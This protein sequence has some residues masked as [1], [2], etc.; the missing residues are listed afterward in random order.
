MKHFYLTKKINNI[1]STILILLGLKEE[2][3]GLTTTTTSSSVIHFDTRNRFGLYS[4]K[5]ALVFLLFA[6]MGAKAQIGV[7][8]TGNTNTTPNLAASYTTLA[9]ALSALNATTAMTGPVTLTLTADTSET[10]PATGLVI[11]SAS[12]NAVLSATNT[13]TIV[14]AGGTVTLNA[15]VGTLSPT[16]TNTEGILKLAGADWITIDGL[17]LTDGNTTTPGTMEVGIGMYKL[18][19][20]DGCN[21]NTIQ[22]CTINM[23]RINN[24]TGTNPIVEGAV[25]IGMYNSTLTAATTVLTVTAASGSNSNNK[26]YSNTINGGNYGMALIGFAAATPF[27][28]ADQGNDI[29]GTSAGTGNQILNFGGGATTNPSAG[30][31][32]LAQYGIS[33]RYNT[34]NNNNGSGVNH[35]ITLRGIY[36]NTATSA[37]ATISNNTVVLKSGAT[38]SEC[39]AIQNA[40]GSTAAS[41]TITISNNN[42]S[43]ANSTSTTGVWSG[44]INSGTA[45]TVNIDGNTMTGFNLA[46]TGTCVMIGT[47]SPTTATASNNSITSITRSGAFGNWRIIITTSPTNFTANGNTIDGLSWTAAAST[48]SIDGIYSNSSAVNVTANNNIIRN[49]STPSTGTIT[50]IKEFGL[51]G[52]KT[53]QNNQIYNFFTTSGGAGGANF[54]GIDEST[55]S[56]NVYS[57]NRIYSF[58]STGSTGGTSGNIVGITFSGGT[59]N[60]VFGNKI[61]DLSS[62]S[63]NPSIEGIKVTGT[64]FAGGLTNN[65]YNNIIGDLKAPAASS[66]DPIRGI[67]ITSITPLSTQNV[68]G[69]TVYLNAASS[70]ANFGSSGLYHTYSAT[71]TTSA[72]DMRNNII[73]NASSSAGT[74]FAVAF[75]RSAATDLA[76]YATTSNNNMFFGTSGLFTDGTNRDTSLSAFQT[77]VST[78]ETASKTQNPSFASTTGADATFL[79]FVA[80]AV[81]LAGSNGQVIAGYTTDFDGDTRDASTPDIG[82]DEWVNGVI[83]LPTITSFSPLVLCTEGGQTVTLTGTGFGTATAV[84]FNGA[85][86]QDSLSG[87]ITAATATSLTV[88]TPVG[89]VDGSITVLNPAGQVTS[90]A[91]Y[92]AASAPTVG[93]SPAATICSG[94]STTLTGTGGAT[95][96]WTPSLGLNGTTTASVIASPT[97]TTTYTVRGFNEFGCNATATVAV[98]V[99]LA[100]PAITATASNT[101]PCIG[102]AVNLTS[103]SGNIPTSSIETFDSVESITANGWTFLNAGFGSAWA[104]TT[105]AARV[106][107]TPGALQYSYNSANAA[108]AWVFSPPRSLTAGITYTI[109][110]WYN[111]GGFAENLKLT[112]GTLNSVASQTTTL[113]TQSGVTNSVFAQATATFTPTTT[114]TYYF[115]LHCFSEADQ[116]FISVDDFTIISPIPATYAWTSSPSGYTSSAQNPTGVTPTVAT[117]Y[118]VE[119]TANGCSKTSS[120]TVTPNAL[121][122]VT[123]NSETVCLGQNATITATPGEAGTYSYAWTVPSG[124]TNPGNEAS[125]SAGTAGNYSVII[126]NTATTCASASASGTITVNQPVVITSQPANSVVLENTQASFSVTATGAGLTY[127][128]YEND[129]G[130]LAVIEGATSATYTINSAA[131]SLNGRLYLCIVTGT[132]STETSSS[133]TL[134]VSDVSIAAQP[135]PQTICSNSSATFSVTAE[136]NVTS[137]QWQVRTSLFSSWTDVLGAN[138]SSITVSGLTATNNSGNNYRCV[139]NAGAVTS[140]Q[141]KLTVYDA[142]AFTTQPASAAVCSGVN[143][144]FNAFA[145]GSGLSYQW[146]MNNG[147][148]WADISGATTASYTVT[149]PTGSMNG[150][151]YRLVASGTAPCTPLVSDAVTLTVTDVSVATSSASICIGGATTLNATFVGAPDYTTATWTSTTGSGAETAVSGASVS[152]TPTAAGSYTYTFASNGTCPFTKTVAVTVN[153]LPIISSVTATPATVCSDANISLAAASV[154]V[155]SGNVLVGT[156][157]TSNTGA[158]YPSPFGN[159]YYGAKQQFLVT[160]SELSALGLA[161]GN[162]TSIAFDVVTPATTPLVNYTIAAKATSNSALTTTFESGLSTLFTAASYVPSASA[163]YN[164]NTITFTTPFNWNGTSNIVFEICFNNSGYTTNAVS[165]ASAAPANS[166][167]FTA[168]DNG[169]VC[170]TSTGTLASVRSNMRFA[171]TLNTNLASTYNWSWNTTPAVATALGTTT[172]TNTSGASVSQTFT[173]TATNAS[174]CTSSLTSTPITVN[175]TI[176]APTATN[177]AQCGTVTPTCSVTGT[178]RVGATFKWYLVATN[179]TALAGQTASTLTSYPTAADT[180]FYVS[181]VSADGLCESPRVAVS[182]TV[183]T[184]FEFTLS[185]ATATNCSGVNSLTPVTIATNDGYTSY[186]W[187]NDATVS[188]NETTGWSF[189]PSTSTT[190]TVTASGGLC[191][192]TANVVVTTTAL[193]VLTATAVP[194]AVCVGAS[195]AI[196]VLTPVIGAGTGAFGTGALTSTGTGAS[197]FPGAW[198]GAKSQYIIKASELTAQGFVA[199]NLTSL[200]FEPTTSGQTYQGFTVNLSSTTDAETTTTFLPVGTQVFSGTGTDGGYTPTANAVNNLAFGT[201]LGSASSFSWNGT[202]NVVVTFSWSL[203]PAAGTSSGSTVKYYAPGFTCGVYKQSDNLAPVDMLA[204]ATG[205]TTTSRPFMTLG[206]QKTIQGVGTLAYTW[207]D[208]SA[209]TGNVLT[210][211]PAA[212][213]V[214]TVSG[215]NATT[216]CTGTS[217]ATVTVFSPPTAPS[218][219]NAN[220]CGTAVPSIAVADTNG[221]T[222]PVF[223]WYAD[224][225]TTTAL[226]TSTSTTYTTSV[227][228]T[229]TFY[230]SVVSPGGCESTRTAVTTTVIAPA[231]LTVSPAVT[232]CTGD[233]TTLTA[234]GAVSYTWTPALGLNGTTGASVSAS[235]S[236]NTTYSVT[237]VDENGCT[238]AAATVAVTVALYPSAVTITQG[239]ASVCADSV[240]SLTATG[241]TIG[242]TGSGKIGS[243]TATNTASTPFKGYF[244]GSKTQQLYTAAELTA[245]GLVSG[246][247]ISSIG[248]VVLSGTPNLLNGFTVN[249]GLVTAATLGTAFIAGANTNVFSNATYTPS[250]G[251]GNIDYALSTPLTWNGISNLLVETCF[252]NNNGGGSF[253][254]DMSVESTTVA[255]GLNLYKAQDNTVDVCTNLAAPTASTNRPNLRISYNAPPTIISWTPTTDLYSNAGATTA[256]SGENA[257]VVYTKPT[258][259]ITYTATASNGACS[260]SNT[261]TVTPLA[262]PNFTLTSNVTICKGQSTTLEALGSGYTYVWT[263]AL[264]LNGTTSAS[265]SA[266]PT[267][268]TTYS[269]EATDSVTGCKATQQVVVTVS[270]PGAINPIGTTTS[271]IAVPGGTATFTVATASGAT[272]TYQWQ[273]NSGS[274]FV[275]VVND[276]TY[277]GAD[278]ASLSISDIQESFDTY[279]YQCLVTGASPCAT[280]TPIVAT[281][282]VSTTGIAQQPASVTLCETNTTT[283]FTV[284]TSGDEPYGIQWQMSTDNGATYND[285]AAGLD[286]TGLTFSGV[287]T[288]TL[289]VSGVSLAN[290]GVKFICV[291]NFFLPSDAATLTVK[292]AV[293]VT[294]QPTNQTVCASGGTA[295]FTTAATGD[296]L[297]YQWEVSTN[298]TTWANY[299]GTGATTA[300]I[301]IVNPAT[302]ADGTQYRVIVSGN[303][304]CTSVTSAAASLLINNPTIT[305]APTAATVLQGN[306]ATFTVTASAATSYQ[307]Q[308]SATLNGTY[309]NVVDAAPAGATYQGADSASLLVLTSSSSASGAG[310]FYRCVV[311]NN[312]CSITSTGVLL[313]VAAYCTPAPS[314]VDGIGITNVTMGDINNTTVAETGNYG[315]YTAYSTTAAQLATVNFA[316]TY[317]TGFNYG[318]KIWIDF[319]DN[320]LFTDAGEQVY[321][322]LSTATNPTTLSGSFVIPLTAAVGSHRMRIGA[323]DTDT[324][325]DPCYTGTFATFEDYTITVTPA[326]TCSGTPLAGTAAAVNG[327]ICTGN[328]TTVNLTGQTTGVTNIVL[329]WYSSTDGTTFT[330]IS[331]ATTATL[332]TGALTANT[333]YYCAVTCSN[334]SETVN[335]NTVIITVQDPQITA[336]TPAGRCG[337]G[338]VSLGATAN[339]GSS[340]NW[341]A[342][343]NGGS[344]IG[345]GTTLTTPSIAATTTYYA[346]AYTGAGIFNGARTAPQVAS[347]STAFGYGLVFDATTAFT[348]NSVDLFNGSTSSGTFVIQL[349]NSAGTVLQTSGTFTAPAGTGSVATNPAYT[350]NLGWNIPVGTGYRLLVTTSSVTLVRESAVGGFPYALGSVGSIT[351]GYISGASTT[352][353]YLYNWKV[354]A[355]CVSTRTAVTATV[356]PQPTAS[357]SYATPLC[358]TATVVPF[359][360][361]GTNAY[362]GGTY[363]STAGLTIDAVTG[364]I[365]VATST[366][367]TYTVT[368]A[369]PD[370]GFCSGLSA[371]TSVTINQALTSDFAYDVATYCTNQG[372]ATPTMTGAAGTFTASPA[373]LSINA[374]TGAITLAS[375]AAGTYTVTNTVVVAGCAN[376]V[377]TASVTVNSAVVITTQ[378]SS[379]SQLPGDNSSFSVAATGTGLAYQWQVNDGTGYVD[380]SGATTNS[381][382]LTAVT[383]EMNGYL[384]QV[385]VSGAAACNSVTSSAALLTVSTAAIAT[386]PANFTACNEGANTAT[387]AVT[388]TGTVTSYQWQLSTNGTTWSDITNGGIY[389][390]ADTATLSLSGLT[391]ANDTNQFRCVLNGVVNSNA[392]TLTIKTAVAITTQPSNTAGCSAGSASF[393]VAASGSD[394]S[395]QWQ[396]STNGTSWTDV[397]GATS[398]TL[399]L[400]ALTA[401]M[402]GYQYQAIVSGAS[403]CSPVTS[404]AAT[405]TVNTAV[406]VSVQP[407]STTACNAANATFS[408]TATGTAPTYQ[409]QMSTNGTSWSDVSGETTASLTVTSVTVAMSGYSYRAVVSGAAP[410]GSVNSS[411]AVLT[412]SQPAAPIVSLPNADVCADVPTLLSVS[413]PTF[414]TTSGTVTLGT[415]TTATTGTSTGTALGP[416]PMQSYYGGTRQQMIIPASELAAIGITNGMPINSV[417]INLSAVESTRLLQN[418]TV[419]MKNTT[420]TAFANTTFET[421]ATTVRAAA[422]Q[423]PVAG[424]NT[425]ALSSNFIYNGQSLL[426]EF[427]FSNADGGGS[428]TSTALHTATTYASSLF[429]RA[430]NTSAATVAAATTA[431]YSQNRRNNIRFGVLSANTTWSPST[432]LYTNAEGTTA[433]TGTGASQV[434]VRTNA[435]TSYTVTNTNALGCTNTSPVNVNVLTPSTL[436]SITQPLVT[437]SGAL[438]SFNLTGL[439]PNS[440]STLSYTVNAGATQTVAGVV[441]DASGN[442]TFTRSFSGSNNGQTIAVTSILRT[443][444]TPNCSTAI[445]A[446]NTV[447]ISVQPL[448]TY[449]ADADGDG[450]GDIAVLQ[451]TCQGQPSG[452]VTNNTDCNDADATKNATFTFYADGDADG[453][454]AGSAVVL[455]AVNSTTPPAGYSANNTD[456]NDADATVNATF[457]FYADNDADGFGA[458]SAVTLCAVNATTPPAGYSVNNTDCN[459]SDNA[460]NAIVTTT[461]TEIVCD[462]YTWSVNSTTY[463]AS[464]TQTVI[465]NSCDTRVLNLTV[466]N[467][468]SGTTSTT[469][470]DSYTWAAPLGNGTTYTSSQTGITNVSTNAAGCPHTQTLNLTIN[471]STSESASETACDSYTWTA[472]TGT[473]YNASGTYTST[474]LNAAGCTDTKILVLTINNSTSESASETA[475]DSYT[476]TAGTGDT[477]TASGT[478]TSTSTNAAGCTHTKTLVLTINN[479]SSESASETA[480]DSYTW[481]AGTGTTYTASG[482]YTSTGLNAAGCTLTKTLVLTINNSTSSVET[483][484]SPT[485]GTYTWSA[486]STTYTS[487]GTYT[488]T[489]TNAAGCTDTKTL[490]LTIN[491]CESVVTVKMNIQ[492]FTLPNGMMK[493]VMAIQGVGSSTTDVDN[494]TIELHNTSAPFATFATTTAMLQTNGDAVATFSSAPVGSFYIVVKH[495]NSLETWSSAP[496][497]VGATP[498]TYDFTTAANKA[499]GN[500]MIQLESGVYG[501]YSGDLNQDGF[502]ESGDYPSLNNDSDAG[503]EGYYSTDLNGDGFVESGDYPILNN[504]S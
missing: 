464:T 107:S 371:T 366:P 405:L 15:G 53:Y 473:T 16:A 362:T 448:V 84:K 188:G 28:L 153:A 446:N 74:G 443:D 479:S 52:L 134:T 463:T 292:N 454:G 163:G 462:T 216:G 210:A 69:N 176:P 133:A 150:Y 313:T 291:L 214:Y 122:T 234:S 215:Y 450:F 197:M 222:T 306:T 97:T 110:Y 114:G 502:I 109:S 66:N 496:Q 500:N 186:S 307:W 137:Y 344:V 170:S 268:T 123:V 297:A 47:G 498:L 398:A 458:G 219:T 98:T 351:S 400:T 486:N 38:T 317:A 189:N 11:G 382:T 154:V 278:T 283:T 4:F 432:G 199:G 65:V 196:T 185:S 374:A 129:G 447:T 250:T 265:V 238:T 244:G 6:S 475:C 470:C 449:Y 342:S 19:A 76:N 438:T 56:T 61:Y 87:T 182:V 135:A 319:N 209:T 295:I 341:Y 128:W 26:F 201:G 336:T 50:G 257:N 357:I 440:T 177:S 178:G 144:S 477:Y 270:E 92:T 94:S 425:I 13:V 235:P 276:S 381:L 72:L 117:T 322:G 40:S 328:E 437:C 183:T 115:G 187:S 126:T 483:V 248:F 184:P 211:T 309:A 427:T 205:T 490:V 338:T 203:V 2:S 418:F 288:T 472:G 279:Q 433:Y 212:T 96:T 480:C 422:T 130:G 333:S 390:N 331:G 179:G 35:A 392:A 415:G 256:Y 439:L 239:A 461:T 260:V 387:F 386:H 221:Y 12:L 233:T 241:G 468:S 455:C 296:D 460:I 237:G 223:K 457:T 355:G 60:N 171:G 142:V 191:T 303:A 75:R 429:Y 353:Y 140:N 444:L 232:I 82:A 329:Q 7:T 363:S 482:T 379:V 369:I 421:G 3:V 259:E 441:A 267:V 5:A 414:G 326:P 360:L 70:G 85:G 202:S 352:Y 395:Y 190:Y 37:S 151:Q 225:T 51:S 208:P 21:N 20:T 77:R 471:N 91:T 125:F 200:A 166:Y 99:N 157:T 378:P 364:A 487:S 298:G 370:S 147:T 401:A 131:L 262:L 456:C 145:T 491:P 164:D 404:S 224:D 412:V 280:L 167:L 493:P 346:Q 337:T 408:V 290:S 459:D 282:T 175:A 59:T 445:T 226:Q 285:I 499:Y 27:T 402:N 24:T 469:A 315:N 49:L 300:S 104:F 274:G 55:G 399:N 204:Q 478:Y 73:V 410:C 372:T 325:V 339:A 321:F 323:S 81:N 305:A 90:I 93:V 434:Y 54:R 423:T 71:A 320:G 356:T 101:S 251:A 124:V 180:T 102:S 139:L 100:P 277:A 148:S 258:S 385:V 359:T 127:Q 430:D 312:G 327:T 29:G 253:S 106:R 79:H 343:L 316:I 174:G 417:A 207:N 348:L 426:V 428:G 481:T 255:S 227:S 44:I 349:Q 358:S 272:Y 116:F 118:T 8:I 18:S 17:T 495:R 271:Q 266:N 132:C 156:A 229:T 162:I 451:V 57:G 388:T 396:V 299:T 286:A 34:V 25:G 149:A 67:S 141:A 310:L 345:T 453:F 393:T 242:A 228:A 173:A 311:T 419:K 63:T 108:N 41:N 160:A 43:G 501:F 168:Q 431:S 330:P 146:Q 314:S 269:V 194:A 31:R 143:A 254:N 48:G 36:L 169:T 302:T 138:A 406:A 86:G 120:V 252:N 474:G 492:G 335:S 23:Q 111:T 46:G 376:S 407:A 249:A 217:T 375:S 165:R 113:S 80:D 503:L 261:T 347:G 247:T 380:I 411:A 112:V 365:D 220:Q 78:R 294:T 14:K 198:G 45:A 246:S 172:V 289:G 340:I 304:A 334:N 424:W 68:Y 83:S 394:L 181:E 273:V 308:S 136:G 263:P 466:N 324:G 155:S 213:T 467:S 159:Y 95:Y 119:A 193:P 230:V 218:V 361:S 293:L 284:V 10:A 484:T 231:T 30:I 121:P 318:T 494:V 103:T 22:N 58:N 497:T 368:Y 275:N 281:L 161:A 489:S 64:A 42:V 105:T 435:S 442:A 391:L 485:C 195:S 397:S 9:S 420:T 504:N 383:T 287:D 409:W 192:T 436:G 33:V 39:T 377:T 240:M 1:V 32:T 354:Q 158:Q 384:Y 452:F 367:G 243:G 301:S 245:L 465:V 62:T 488:S 88:S 236:A 373:G 476:W 350:A 332:S 416:N 413:N 389:A 152:V 89:V 264:G 206:G 403:P